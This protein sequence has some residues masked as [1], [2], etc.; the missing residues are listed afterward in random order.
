M[1]NSLFVKPT[2]PEVKVRRP[3]L[4][5]AYLPEDGASVPKSSYWLRRI[6]EGDVVDV[7]DAQVSR[8]QGSEGA[9]KPPKKANKEK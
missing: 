7:Q 6:K 8:S 3:E 5:G 1:N 2:N 4:D 9:T